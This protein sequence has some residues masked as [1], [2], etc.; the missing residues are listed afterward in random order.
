M[1]ILQCGHTPKTCRR[2]YRCSSTGNYYLE[3]CSKCTSLE[4]TEFLIKE[5][6]LG[7]KP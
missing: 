5:E 7:E 4:S 2:L 1:D 6:S 3:L